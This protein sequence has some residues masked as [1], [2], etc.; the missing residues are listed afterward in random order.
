VTNGG[1]GPHCAGQPGA[2]EQYEVLRAT[3]LG[4]VLPPEARSGLSILLYRGLWA[5]ARTI[6]HA[7]CRPRPIVAPPMAG[8]PVAD[9]PSNRHTIIRVLATIMM[10]PPERRTL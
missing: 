5:W 1:A 4:A 10:A 3:A 7:P 9:E 2:T 6:L 8:L